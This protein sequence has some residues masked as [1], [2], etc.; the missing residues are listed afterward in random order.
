[1]PNQSEKEGQMNKVAV[2]GHLGDCMETVKAFI[3]SL[4]A[5]LA[6]AATEDRKSTRL[7][8]SH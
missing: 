4:V 8:S 5:E 6:Q 1:M 7:N 3:Q 2:L